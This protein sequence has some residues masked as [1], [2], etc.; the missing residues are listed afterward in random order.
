M[1]SPAGVRLLQ[2]AC[3]RERLQDDQ[4]LFL[5]QDEDFLLGEKSRAI[6][7]LSA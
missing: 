7:V 5:M 3:I 6:V 4:V 2:D 1:V